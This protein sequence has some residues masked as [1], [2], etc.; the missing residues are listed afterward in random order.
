M[1][2]ITIKEAIELTKE[3]A[4]QNEKAWQEYFASENPEKTFFE[5]CEDLNEA[6][7]EVWIAIRKAFIGR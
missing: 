7:K 5:K 6:W 1:K 2:K 3:Q 4:R